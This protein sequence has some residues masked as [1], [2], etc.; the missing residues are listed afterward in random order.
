MALIDEIV[1]LLL[2]FGIER[3]RLS[4]EPSVEIANVVLRRAGRVGEHAAER[5]QRDR[6]T[7]QDP[8]DLLAV[9]GY[10]DQRRRA[11]AAAGGRAGR[12]ADVHRP[13]AAGVGAARLDGHCSGA[14]AGGGAT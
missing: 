7:G 6:A 10:Q 12:A 14:T 8:G 5:R 11:S 2:G 3:D 4:S 9:A 1:V 13:S